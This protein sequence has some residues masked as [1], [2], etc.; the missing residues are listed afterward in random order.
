M[1]PE[2]M[3]VNDHY[4]LGIDVRTGSA[5]AGVFDASGNMPAAAKHEVGHSRVRSAVL[6]VKDHD[7]CCLPTLVLR[8][9]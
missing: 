2:I 5:R 6:P 4:Y 3:Q 8:H 1:E 7:E 9:S